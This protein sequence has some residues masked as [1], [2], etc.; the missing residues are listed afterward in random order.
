MFVIP[1]LS[2]SKGGYFL[3]RKNQLMEVE[4]CQL[5]S[6]E[7]RKRDRHLIHFLCSLGLFHR[8]VLLSGT[9]LSPWATIHNADALRVSI[10][11]QTGCL[12]STEPTDEDI[13]P[14]LRSR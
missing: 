11:Q 2:I 5:D 3:S 7:C 10:G 6:L 13:A 14:C 12:S 4:N 1:A 9:A 8:V